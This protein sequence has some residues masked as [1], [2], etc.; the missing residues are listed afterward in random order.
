MRIKLIIRKGIIKVIRKY[1]IGIGAIIAYI[2]LKYFNLEIVPDYLNLSSL[3]A[4]NYF[5]IL[6]S[7]TAS[8]FGILVAVILITFEFVKQSAFR[9]KDQN[10]LTKAVVTNLV[11]IAVSIIVLS[12]LSYSTIP[13]FEQSNNLSIAYLLGFLFVGFIVAIY[14]ASKE[15]LESANTL[16][17]TIIQIK[18][19]SIENFREVYSLDDK[20][21]IAKNDDLALIRIRHELLKAVRECDYE[22]YAKILREL[23]NK[24]IEIIGDGQNRQNTRIIFNGISFVWNSSNFE[25]L[26]VGNYQFYENIWECIEE[27]Y[28]YAAKRNI[29]L[30]HYEV[31]YFF[32]GDFLK[33]LSS[34][35]LGDSLAKGAKTI[36]SI[37]KQNLKFNCPP[38]EKINRLYSIFGD[39][40]NMPHYIDSNLQWEKINEFIYLLNTI[41]ISSIENIDKELFDT[42]R[43]ELIY[44]IKEIGYNQFP[45]LKVYQEAFIVIQII[46][47]LTYNALNAIEEN[48]FKQSM[49]AFKISPSSISDLI[50]KERFYIRRILEE[51]SDYLIISQRKEHLDDIVSLN[52]WGALGRM[53][54]EY[55]LTNSTAQ[56]AMDYILDTFIQLKYEI[57]NYQLPSQAKNY[58]EI[59]NQLETIKKWLKKDNE[60]KEIPVIKKIDKTINEFREVKEETDFR[61]VKWVDDDT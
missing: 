13:D 21:F 15:I 14:P 37:F 38:Q 4:K 43:F 3:N 17:K 20:K 53:I 10:V 44:I 40:E 25:A 39:D 51:I 32:L 34:N 36:S 18:S 57:E 52:D 61:I 22:A 60:G 28:E 24:A 35:N 33:F 6:L 27:L 31:L 11:A 23:N 26:R 12:L 19:L 58:K 50:K 55:Y 7:S 56:K 16:K 49:W 29:S 1:F 48:L 2:L 42:C 45:N 9:R 5:E 47:H 46:S 41:Q 54:S 59:R 30:L 8:V